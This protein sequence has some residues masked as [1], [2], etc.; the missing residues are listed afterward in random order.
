MKPAYLEGY[1]LYV[2]FV[3]RFAGTASSLWWFARTTGSHS[4]GLLELLAPHDGVP[5]LL[6]K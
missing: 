4:K 5:E 3:H 6:D 2:T 1:V